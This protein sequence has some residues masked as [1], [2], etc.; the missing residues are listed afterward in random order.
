MELAIQH[1]VIRPDAVQFRGYQANLARIAGQKDALVV[2]PTGMG[3]TVVAL[4]VLADAWKQGARRILMMAPTR[5]L[6]EQHAAYLQDTLAEDWGGEVHALTGTVPPSKRE[7]A[8]AAQGIVVATPQVIHNDLIAGR[9]EQLP[10]WVV[11]D[12]CH[13]AVGDYAYTFIGDTLRAKKPSHRRMGLT[14]SPGHDVQKIHEVRLHLGLDHVEIRTPQDPDVSEYVRDVDVEWE[15]LPLP[16]TMGKVTGLLQEALDERLKML[17]ATDLLR[18]TGRPT[19]R[20]LLEVAKKAQQAIRNS[21][22]PDASWFQALS[23]QAQCMKL[24]H[25]IEQV[26]TQGAMAFVAYME[27]LRKE[28]DGP[29]ASKAS[30]NIA[31]DDRL[32]MAYHVARHDDAENPKIGRVEALVQE[33]LEHGP[34]SRIIVFT[35]FR[36]TCE[37]VTQRLS[38]LTGVR[39]VVF[40]GQGKRKGQ[41]GLTQK[42]QAEVLARFREGEHNVLVATSVAEEGLDIPATDLVVFYEPIGS[43]IRSIQRRGRTGPHGQG[44]V[45]VLMTK[46]TADEA[47]HWSSRRKEQAMVK[48]LQ[49]LRAALSGTAPATSKGQ[50]RIDDHAAKPAP[51]DPTGRPMTEG[52]MVVCDSREQAGGVMRHLSSMGA[53]I[54]TKSLD[55]ADFILSDRVA[56][57]RKA[58]SDFVDSLIDGR[59]F[60]QMARLKDYPKPILVLEGD[61]VLG[62]RNVAPEAV[63]GALASVGTD[64]GITVLQ[65]RDALETA[66]L[67][68][69]IAKREQGREGRHVGI[70]N[71]HNIADDDAVAIAVLSQLPGINATKATALLGAF[72][73]LHAVLDADEAMLQSVDG[74]G[75][76]LA[77]EIHRLARRTFTG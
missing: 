20:T 63:M 57:E 2:L 56:V 41:D 45:V 23:L 40:V 66:R 77:G 58:S 55:I 42:Q 32:N 60:E 35:H 62:H 11:Y 68:I 22:D 70:R 71:A 34:D 47:A 12:E 21:S 75:P 24:M 38:E 44:R 51:S 15:T 52:P 69:A 49:G 72:G 18:G 74:I 61:G 30:R 50:T 53:R 29:K 36:T 31:H 19:K 16:P 28:A 26:Q 9:M 27:Q 4:L 43:E 65:T 14:A 10:D 73:S 59:L 6:V 8:Y 33:Q 76:K 1:P 5:P 48:E 46:G 3:K 64:Y 13:R 17:R 7:A 25:A 39:P 37:Q 67:L 54:E